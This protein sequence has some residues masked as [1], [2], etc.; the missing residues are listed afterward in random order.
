MPN[1]TQKQL[2]IVVALIR[3]SRG[4]ILLQKRC[5][6]HFPTADGKWE[7]PGGKIDFGESLEDAVRR[8]CREEIGCDMVIKRFLPQVQTRVWERADGGRL[9]VFV[10]CFEGCLSSGDPKPCDDKVSEVRWCTREELGELD[11]LPGIQEFV[12]MCY[13]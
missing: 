6:P 4:K 7:F 12:E 10:C 5:D 13:S 9:Q 3:D 11:T 1:E 8:E 2:V